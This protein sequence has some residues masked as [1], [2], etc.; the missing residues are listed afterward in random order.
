MSDGIF[1]MPNRLCQFDRLWPFSN[2][3]WKDRKEALYLKNQWTASMGDD[4][5]SA[6]AAS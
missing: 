1:S 5:R 6:A 3:H 2:A 4:A